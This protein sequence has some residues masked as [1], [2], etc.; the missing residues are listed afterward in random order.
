MLSNKLLLASG[1]GEG[2]ILVNDVFATALRTGTGADATITTGIDMTQGYMVWTKGRSGATDHAIYD[3]ARGV[4]F[5]LVS[6]STAA[7]T[8]QA[9]GLKSVSSTGYTIGSLAKMNTSSATYVDFTFRQA[10]K[11]FDVVTYTGDGVAGREIAHNLG[12]VPGIVLIKR[13]SSVEDWHIKHISIAPEYNTRLNLTTGLFGPNIAV[14]NNTAPTDSVFTVGTDGGVNGNGATYI[15]YLFAHDP[16]GVIQCGSY[17]GNF[18]TDGP[19][20]NIGWEPQYLLIKQSSGGGGDWIV[21]DSVRGMTV[22]GAESLYPN[23]SDAES[24]WTG[25]TIYPTSTGFKIARATSLFNASGA[26]YI[27]LAIKKAA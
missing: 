27:Y 6:N 24:S 15:A 18:S 16:D 23:K 14:F 20:I 8:T 12:V 5:D 21:F 25:E 1:G 7:Q 9:Q 26:T 19:E 22:S 13:T 17:I 4:T 3:S 11:F 2:T 10:P